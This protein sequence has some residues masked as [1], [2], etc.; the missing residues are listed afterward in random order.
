MV[1]EA[2]DPGR[3]ATLTGLAE[4]LKMPTLTVT[5]TAWERS[6]L[7]S[8]TVTEQMFGVEELKVQFALA[9]PPDGTGTLDVHDTVRPVAGG[10]DV[11]KLTAPEKAPRL[12]RMTFL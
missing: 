4:M 9:V 5:T 12:P 6:P 7:V 1:D 2:D 3:R 11:D 10:V 8:V